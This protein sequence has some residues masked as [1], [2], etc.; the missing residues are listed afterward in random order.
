ML[1][2]RSLPVTL[3]ARNVGITAIAIHHATTHLVL[4]KI[5]SLGIGHAVKN[6][7]QRAFLFT[8]GA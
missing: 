6:L 7:A 8:P 4:L 5:K 2:S 1:I 3:T